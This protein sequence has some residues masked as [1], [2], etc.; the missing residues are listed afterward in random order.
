MIAENKLGERIQAIPHG[1]GNCPCCK[2][3]LIAKCGS[4][5]TWHW[6]HLAADCDPWYEGESDWHLNWKT[7]FGL[8]NCEI[9]IGKHRADVKVHET[10]IELQ[11]SSISAAEIR[12]R[13]EFYGKMIWIFDASEFKE[14]IDVRKAGGYCTFRWK[15]P[16]QSI[17][18]CERPVFLDFGHFLFAIH[19]IYT[20]L[21]C[22]GWGRWN[23]PNV[24][25]ARLREGEIKTADRAVHSPEIGYGKL[26]IKNPK[27]IGR[28]ESLTEKLER[29]PI[30][31][32][33]QEFYDESSFRDKL[34]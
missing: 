4:I 32:A 25:M 26:L 10:V 18:H 7:F 28:W 29:M 22:G 2:S 1:S 16:R 12:E 17:W 34:G 24:F 3:A 20:D 14:N 5:K 11:H 21:P 6:S 19:K 8:D 23:H 30:K 15:H 13:E 31:Q 33:M 27:F 9:T